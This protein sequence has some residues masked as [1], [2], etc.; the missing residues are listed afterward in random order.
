MTSI[1]DTCHVNLWQQFTNFLDIHR[2]HDITAPGRNQQGRDLDGRQVLV[3]IV[4]MEPIK[5]GDYGA[6]VTR[7]QPFG[8]QA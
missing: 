5:T 8:T 3:H 6:L 7:V 1:V 4:A 2:Q